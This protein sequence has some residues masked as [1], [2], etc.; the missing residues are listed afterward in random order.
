LLR[1]LS[2]RQQ[3]GARCSRGSARSSWSRSLANSP[4]TAGRSRRW[5]RRPVNGSARR[6][7]RRNDARSDP[8]ERCEQPTGP[9]P[10]PENGSAP[11]FAHTVMRH[12][13]AYM[14]RDKDVDDS[15]CAPPAEPNPANSGTDHP[16]AL[17]R[18]NPYE[19]S[20]MFPE[21][22]A[23]KA[24]E[25]VGVSMRPGNGV[26]GGVR[27]LLRIVDDFVQTQA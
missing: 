11:H 3:R 23:V 27:E 19:R 18:P 10:T 16:C 14:S 2:C 9:R 7:H 26:P 22:R 12:Q 20:R 6:A 24:A 21:K 8:R 15:R 4:G 1:G 5:S 17:T 13:P 25:R